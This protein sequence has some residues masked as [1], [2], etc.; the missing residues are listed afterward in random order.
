MWLVALD[1]HFHFNRSHE[2]SLASFVL[3]DIFL[4]VALQR[5][6]PNTKVGNRELLSQ[7]SPFSLNIASLCHP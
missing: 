3:R 5:K 2:I 4:A 1:W 6:H 7:S